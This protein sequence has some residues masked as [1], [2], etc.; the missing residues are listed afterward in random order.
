MQ[1]ESNEQSKEAFLVITRDQSVFDPSTPTGKFISDISSVVPELHI[2]CISHK[3]KPPQKLNDN[4]WIYTARNIPFL[5]FASVNYVVRSQL[6]WKRHFRPSTIISIGDEV[7]I[8]RKLSSKYKRP[9]FVFYSYM[10]L[11]GKSDISI[12]ALVKSKPH[13]IFIPN[14][15]VG[16]AITGH[17]HFKASDT[18]VVILPEFIDVNK[19]ENILS[20]DHT[21][22]IVDSRNKI[23]TM[24]V[25]PR[26]AN[27]RCFN[28]IRDISKEL[29]TFMPKFKFII[30][31]KNRQY[32]Q[33]RILR[34][35]LGIPLEIIRE[36][37]NSTNLFRISRLM[38]YFDTP[39]TPYKPILYS[40][41]AGCPVLSSGDEYSKIVLFN[42][43]LE[44]YSHLPRDGKA[45]GS[46]VK[47]LVADQYLYTKYKMNCIG[48]AKTAFTHDKDAYLELLRNS[49]NTNI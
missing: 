12:G 31:V 4:T 28:F 48:F 46:T 20:S 29:L 21:A 37:D 25:F 18:S 6:V 32:L 45:F 7:A 30:V 5:G 39:T 9:L 27:L 16:K 14:A 43:G 11:L 17:S 15:Y 41:I 44:E 2:I 42:S 40:F 35:I 1:T 33:A 22:E 34:R 10:K 36:G 8:A 47:K 24:V 19:L 3:S 26:H 38:L 13:K 23:F 49:L